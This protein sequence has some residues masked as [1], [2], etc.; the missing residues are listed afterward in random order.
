MSATADLPIRVQPFSIGKSSIEPSAS[1]LARPRARAPGASP[2]PR[3]ASR[4]GRPRPGRRTRRSGRRGPASTRRSSRGRRRCRRRRGSRGGRRPRGARAGRRSRCRRRS[5]TRGRSRLDTL[6]IA[7]GRILVKIACSFPSCEDRSVLRRAGVL[8]FSRSFGRNRIAAPMGPV[9]AEIEIDVPRAE[10]FAAIADLARRP[11][12]T[13][14][15]LTGFHL[16][17]IESVGRRRRRPLPARPAAALGLDGHRDRRGR[18]P[19]PDRRA[20]P[21]RPRQP[22]PGDDRLGAAR[23]A[24]RR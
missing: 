24:R 5:R 1:R 16:T 22:D 17:R 15:F 9:S 11:S 21:R 2:A 23:G 14:H 6:V 13:D 8:R 10:A 3:P 18:R 19:P 12:F 4:A 7:V 20:R